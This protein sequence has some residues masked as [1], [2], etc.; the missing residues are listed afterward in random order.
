[1]NISTRAE[2]LGSVVPHWALNPALNLAVSDELVHD[3]INVSLYASRANGLV[4]F[5][6]GSMQLIH[7]ARELTGATSI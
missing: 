4:S 1:M 5:Q 6:R 7:L 2:K 3:S